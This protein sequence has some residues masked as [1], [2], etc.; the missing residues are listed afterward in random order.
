M[1]VNGV[2]VKEYNNI[3]SSR[4]GSNSPTFDGTGNTIGDSSA[5]STLGGLSWDTDDHVYPWDGTGFT[6]SKISAVTFATELENGSSAF[7][8]WLETEGR[9]NKDQLGNNR[10]DGSWVP[11]AYQ[12]DI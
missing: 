11:G 12:P 9:L 1:W 10:G 6:Y 5:N 2:T 3:Y 4:G 7:K 8:S